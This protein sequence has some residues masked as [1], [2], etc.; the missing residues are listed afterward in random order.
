MLDKS[1]EAI[2]GRGEAVRRGG[3]GT[4]KA[5]RVIEVGPVVRVHDQGTF[6]FDWFELPAPKVPNGRSSRFGGLPRDASSLLELNHMILT[7]RSLSKGHGKDVTDRVDSLARGGVGQI[8]V[9]VPLGLTRGV[10]DHLE[11]FT[12]RGVHFTRRGRH[13]GLG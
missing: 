13:S 3:P 7:D 1:G 10:G 4:L 2:N 6:F 12:W 9:A 5:C 8:V 11:D